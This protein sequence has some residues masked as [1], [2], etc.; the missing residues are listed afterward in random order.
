MK[1][2]RMNIALVKYSRMF[3]FKFFKKSIFLFSTLFLSFLKCGK[4]VFT[5]ENSLKEVS[6]SENKEEFYKDFIY[7]LDEEKKSNDCH[8]KF[9][10][11]ITVHEYY[12][13]LEKDKRY[14]DEISECSVELEKWLEQRRMEK[15]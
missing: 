3:L 14:E 1:A 11:K 9:N 10:N 2:F 12:N 4:K 5:K 15:K 6:M 8:V 7:D 13:E